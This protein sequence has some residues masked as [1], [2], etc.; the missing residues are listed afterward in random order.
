[1]VLAAGNDY[2]LQSGY[3]D[4]PA[5]VVAASDR[6]DRKPDFSSGVGEA[7]WGMAAPG[8]GSTTDPISDDIY[9]TYYESGQ[10]NSYAYLR[11]TSMAAPHVSGAAAVL[12]G[13]GLSAQ[14]TVERLLSTAKDIGPEGRDTTF[15]YGRLDLAAAVGGPASGSG[16]SDGESGGTE[17]GSG[18]QT[19]GT[20]GGAGPVPRGPAD[21]VST[22]ERS[23]GDRTAPSGDGAVAGDGDRAGQRQGARALD[24]HEGGTS[25]RTPLAAG[26]TLAT[27]IA[28]AVAWGYWRLKLRHTS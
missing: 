20:T 23:L 27:A 24:D 17:G 26:V 4:I 5:I 14:Q 25:G 12:R 1:M 9:S 28:V 22:P 8:G 13:M 10:Q 16:S 18:R 3:A 7:K 19:E 15:G 6:N 21:G 11:G 2:L